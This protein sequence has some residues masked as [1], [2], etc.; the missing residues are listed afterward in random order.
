MKVLIEHTNN[1]GDIVVP[2]N[3]GPYEAPELISLILIKLIVSLGYRMQG[4]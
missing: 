4:I 2:L 3:E 1:L